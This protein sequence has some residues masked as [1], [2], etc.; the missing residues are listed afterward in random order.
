[1]EDLFKCDGR[2]FSAKISG[3]YC[4]GVITVEGHAILLCQ[5]KKEGANSKDKKG[6]KYSWWYKDIDGTTS[7]HVTDFK[8]LD[9]EPNEG[10][11][12]YVSDVDPECKEKHKRLFLNRTKTGASVCVGGDAEAEYLSGKLPFKVVRW[13]YIKLIPKEPLQIVVTIEE[14]LNIVAEQKGVNV[15]QLRIKQ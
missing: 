2:R 9:D 12:V 14:V 13:K 15:K 7:S 5:N 11:W 10:D 4:E 6:F 1:M 8:L 3:A